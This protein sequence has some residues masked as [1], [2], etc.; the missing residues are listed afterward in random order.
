MVNRKSTAAIP[1]AILQLQRQL[2]QFRS[3]PQS[4]LFGQEGF[5]ILRSG[6]LCQPCQCL[7]VVPGIHRWAS[8]QLLGVPQ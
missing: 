3:T 2:E 4:I 6:G 1:E 7:A 5:V 8:L